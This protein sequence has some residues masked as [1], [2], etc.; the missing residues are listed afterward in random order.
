MKKIMLITYLVGSI[1]IA[2][3]LEIDSMKWTQD[4]ELLVNLNSRVESTLEGLDQNKN[5]IRDDVEYYVEH[6]YKDKP[7]QKT[8]FLEAAK[9]IQ[10]IIALPKESIKEHVK[11]DNE[12]LEIYTC[13][14]YMLY[15]LEDKN[16][17]T[18]L[19]EKMIFKSKVLNTNKRLRAYIDHKKLLPFEDD[20]LSDE[21]LDEKRVACQNRYKALTNPDM[22]SSK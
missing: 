15:K 14:D 3:A 9:K 8:L 11:L 13:R 7:F 6:R 4:Y 1:S 2:S 21:I 16:I 5:G 18:E 20:N 17:E 12:L 19:K 10:K 22:V